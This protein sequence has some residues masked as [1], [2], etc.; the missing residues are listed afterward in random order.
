MKP[1]GPMQGSAIGE[2]RW[3]TSH[4][5]AMKILPQRLRRWPLPVWPPVVQNAPMTRLTDR[6]LLFGA[7]MVQA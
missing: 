6:Q 2:I 4:P 7:Q 5:R 1:A 3:V